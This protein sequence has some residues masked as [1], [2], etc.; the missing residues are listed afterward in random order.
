MT[1]NVTLSFFVPVDQPSCRDNEEARI[2]AEI[3]CG[4]TRPTAFAANVIEV[5]NTIDEAAPSA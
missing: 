5:A 4:A 2:S 1:G 3:S